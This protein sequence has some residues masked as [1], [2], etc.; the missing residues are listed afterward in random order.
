MFESII[1]KL[2]A[3]APVNDRLRGKLSTR[4]LFSIIVALTFIFVAV[5]WFGIFLLLNWTTG[6]A[7]SDGSSLAIF[8]TL[9]CTPLIAMLYRSWLRKRW[10]RKSPLTSSDVRELIAYGLEEVKDKGKQLSWEAVT[11]RTQPLHP[12]QPPLSKYTAPRNRFDNGRV[13]TN[14]V[15]GGI[16]CA[17][18]QEGGWAAIPDEAWDFYN[19][20]PS[21]FRAFYSYFN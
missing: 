3:W 17:L 1:E 19:E 16:L 20:N 7:Y 10:S 21:A 18:Y 14:D 4:Y 11:S 6:R 13:T 2:V 5:F 8:E 15:I 12:E 9:A